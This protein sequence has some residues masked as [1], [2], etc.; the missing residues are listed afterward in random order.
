MKIFA[1]LKEIKRREQKVQEGWN[2]YKKIKQVYGQ[3]ISI[4]V[5][6]HPALGD[7]YLA[8]LY[9]NSYY[10]EKRFVVTAISQGAMEVYQYLK[11]EQIYC[12]TQKETD[13]LIIFCQFTGVTQDEIRIL[14]HQALCW[15]TG[16]LWYLQGVKG[17]TFANLFEAAVFPGAKHED[18]DYPTVALQTEVEDFFVEWEIE[19][20][21][22]V[23]LFPYANTLHVP[24]ISFWNELVC[25]FREKGYKVAT[26]VFGK[27]NPICGT[28]AVF[29]KLDQ[30][31]LLAEYAGIV[32]GV[33]NGL[34][35]IVGRAECR[36]IIFYPSEGAA[37]WIHGSIKDYWSLAGFGY[38]DD[39]EEYEY[40]LV[41][42]EEI[43]W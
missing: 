18:R 6:Q 15:H 40:E 36:K 4:C 34:M 31:V 30:L 43:K 14:H 32:A 35:D 11:V 26:Y 17:L 3:D 10:G 24:E 33:R 37:G 9:L 1:N 25:I 16:I 27:E 13:C 42:L 2:I 23:I 39:A 12:L 19:K 38:C 41:K 5:S 20:G 7:A 28:A 22:T 29:C 21:N 8:G